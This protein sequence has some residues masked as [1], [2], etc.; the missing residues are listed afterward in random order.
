MMGLIII[1]VLSALGFPFAAGLL[2]MKLLL[3]KTDAG[4]GFVFFLS[5]GLGMGILAQSMLWLAIFRIPY[6]FITILFALFCIIVCLWVL[7]VMI[8][9]IRWNTFSGLITRAHDHNS[10]LAC[11]LFVLLL[12][13]L[14]YI[15]VR[16]F[17]VPVRGWDTIA[18]ILFKAKVFFYERDLDDLSR[19]PHPAYPLQISFSVA[20]LSLALDRWNEQLAAGSVFWG[21]ILSFLG[22]SWF[23][24]KRLGVSRFWSLMFIALIFSSNLFLAHLFGFYCD[25]PQAYY[26]FFVFACLVVWI[27]E[28]CHAWLY[29]AAVFSGM[30]AF[31]KLEGILYSGIHCLTAFVM[32]WRSSGPRSWKRVAAKMGG[33]LGILSVWIVPFLLYKKMVL[34][35]PSVT[36]QNFNLSMIQISFSLEK[37]R[38]ILWHLWTDIVFSGNWSLMGII[39][40]LTLCMIPRERYRQRPELGMILF[41]LGIF[42]IM[43][44]L[45]FSSTRFYYDVVASH[46]PMSRILMHFFPLIPFFIV[47]VLSDPAGESKYFSGRHSKAV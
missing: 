20:W 31:V 8:L 16:L 40:P 2:L 22:G 34:P 29:L 30:G 24:L 33:F 23:V 7:A 35:P 43:I 10:W 11:F 17:V 45:G 36:E 4:A 18:T 13:N 9:K 44:I 1:P 28:R 21:Y 39:F 26:N 6:D 46:D 14:F 32:L 42:L 5:Y 27:H 19:L 41:S 25:F 12:V 37:L 3:R 38:M 15:G 47:L